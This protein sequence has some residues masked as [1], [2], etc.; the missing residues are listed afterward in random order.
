[1]SEGDNL[2]YNQHR[3]AQLWRDPARGSVPIGWTISPALIQVA[4]AM[5]AYYLRTATP[6]DELL[7]GPSGAGYMLPSRWPGEQLPAFL[8][9]TG[10]LLQR[11]HLATLQVLDSGGLGSMAFTNRSLQQ[12]FV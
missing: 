5:A 1:M 3:M 9:L 10:Q 12:R 2:Q 11:M 7:A 4:P 6:Q 8:P